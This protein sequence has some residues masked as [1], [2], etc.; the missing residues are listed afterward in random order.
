MDNVYKTF[1]KWDC[2]ACN[3]KDFCEH[4]TREGLFSRW[5]DCRTCNPLQWVS[6]REFACAGQLA[7]WS[8]LQARKKQNGMCGHHK[9]GCSS[10]VGWDCPGC[11]RKDRCMECTGCGCEG[12]KKVLKPYCF[13]CTPHMFVIDEQDG[14]RYHKWSNKGREVARRLR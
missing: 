12:A 11:L 3:K 9:V 13:T 8:Y 5:R 2:S 4:L 10:A 7:D 6:L 1:H 14:Q